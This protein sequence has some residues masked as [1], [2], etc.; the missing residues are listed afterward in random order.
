[1]AIPSRNAEP[2]AAVAG[3][4]TFFVESNSWGR[5]FLLQSDRAARLLIDVL[6]HYR[7]EGEY[8]LHAFVVMPN[9]FHALITVNGNSTVERT[10][11]KIKGAFSYRARRDFAAK[12]TGVWQRGF[13]DKRVRTRDEF[14]AYRHYIHMNP[15]RAGLVL[16]P[17]EYPYSSAHP[18]FRATKAPAAEAEINEDADRHDSEVVP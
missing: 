9:H 7:N 1:M 2:E 5:R 12:W 14:L 11:Q 10:M 8:R 18:S 4:R 15:V 16:R 17:E 3:Q 13:S 6:F